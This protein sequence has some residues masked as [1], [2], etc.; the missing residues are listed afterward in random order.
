VFDTVR[1]WCPQA[2]KSPEDAM[3]V[4]TVAR[5][6]LAGPGLAVLF[7][8]HDRKGGG[9]FGE[10]VSGT[11]GLVGAVD[12]LIELKRVSEDPADPRRRMVTSRRF[13]PLDRTAKLEGRRSVLLPGQGQK[14]AA[15]ATVQEAVHQ[16]QMA[17]AKTQPCA[18][19]GKP[20]AEWHHP[21]Y[22]PGAELAVEALCLVCHQPE[23][24][25]PAATVAETVRIITA[26][27]GAMTAAE[28][29]ATLEIQ[30]PAASK[31]MTAAEKAGLL[32]REGGGRH[33]GPPVW[34]VVGSRESELG[35]MHRHRRAHS[36][37]LPG[38]RRAVSRRTAGTSSAVG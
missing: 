3:A 35:V 21:S 24:A 5:Q 16:G 4:M 33:S 13:E 32:K 2:E 22:A 31:R 26:A 25:D 14:V 1:T 30:A 7:V 12:V 34:R 27:G 29:M 10:G 23:T 11:N 18:R 36:R 28:L 8:H 20:A 38:R 37:S 15:R 17:P 6:E 9:A 19:C